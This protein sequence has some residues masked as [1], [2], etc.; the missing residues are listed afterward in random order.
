MKMKIFKQPNKIP[1]KKK[2][3]RLRWSINFQLSVGERL[4]VCECVSVCYWLGDRNC[5][6]FWLFGCPKLW[7]CLFHVYMT[8]CVRF[9]YVCVH[10]QLVFGQIVPTTSQHKRKHEYNQQIDTDADEQVPQIIPFQDYANIV[11]HLWQASLNATT[12]GRFL[13]GK[14][15]GPSSRNNTAKYDEWILCKII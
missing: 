13:A 9:S 5:P 15:N 11:K 12:L 4:C 8:I 1:E 3:N 6:S 7:P 10:F 14:V 2:K